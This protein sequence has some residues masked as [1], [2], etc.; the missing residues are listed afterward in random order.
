MGN[1]DYL[2]GGCDMD[3]CADLPGKLC[4]EKLDKKI[5]KWLCQKIF[6]KIWSKRGGSDPPPPHPLHH[7][8]KKNQIWILCQNPLTRELKIRVVGFVLKK[9]LTYFEMLMVPHALQCVDGCFFVFYRI[10]HFASGIPTPTRIVFSFQIRILCQNSLTRELKIRVVRFA[11]KKLFTHF[12][13][14]IVSHALNCVNGHY[15]VFY[16]FWQSFILFWCHC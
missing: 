1:K 14:L 3:W 15:F 6:I 12:E 8:Q 13:M 2:S 16:L 7:H 4:Y 5:R 9:L 11:L 10:W